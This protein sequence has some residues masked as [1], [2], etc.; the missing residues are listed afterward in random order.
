MTPTNGQQPLRSKT[1]Q[2]FRLALSPTHP[3]KLTL[4]PC[5]LPLDKPTILHTTL[6]AVWTLLESTKAPPDRL[7][8]AVAG[9]LFCANSPLPFGGTKSKPGYTH[10][11]GA[12]TQALV[13]YIV[14]ETYRVYF[15]T[16][17]SAL[18]KFVRACVQSVV[19]MQRGNRKDA[20]DELVLRGMRRA[21][22]V[23]WHGALYIPEWLRHRWEVDAVVPDAKVGWV[24]F[25]VLGTREFRVGCTRV[26]S[27]RSSFGGSSSGGGGRSGEGN[28][29]VSPVSSARGGERRKRRRNC[30]SSNNS[31]DESGDSPG[32]SSGD[33]SGN[34]SGGGSGSSGAQVL[35]SVSW[36]GGGSS[37]EGSYHGHALRRGRRIN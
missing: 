9:K 6:R 19:R 25:S 24:E 22:H 35:P 14:S 1:Q 26:E 36:D 3:D 21:G 29:G 5:P 17:S 34:Q 11:H 31:N 30:A 27:D 7:V 20:V 37:N 28:D 8:Y 13:E 10:F 4:A 15:I 2:S 16:Q 18:L 23:D 12:T 32:G 33:D